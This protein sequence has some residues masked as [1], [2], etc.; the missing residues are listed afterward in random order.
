M[1][2][3]H[4]LIIILIVAVVTAFLRF[5]P[6]LIF[7]KSK[8]PPV[9]EKLSR[10]LPFAVMAMLV[11]YCLKDVSF[12]SFSGFLPELLASFVVVLLYLIKKNTLLSIVSGT[13]FYMILVQFVF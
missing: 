11:V 4:T 2:D 3:L 6:F 13:L 7:G 8:T 1:P 9:I 10:I 12:L 5:L